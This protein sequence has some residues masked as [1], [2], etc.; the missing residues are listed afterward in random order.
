MAGGL[1]LC[2][3]AGFPGR[4]AAQLPAPSASASPAASE[5]PAAPATDTPPR[6]ATRDAVALENGSVYRGVIF[7]LVTGDHV[8]IMLPSGELKTFPMSEVRFAGPDSQMPV[9]AAGPAP[10]RQARGRPSVPATPPGE[11]AVHLT[12]AQ[13]DVTFWVERAGDDGP[14]ATGFSKLCTAPCDAALPAG[15]YRFA[16]A[17][18]GESPRTA[19]QVVNI[20]GDASLRADIVSRRDARTAG[21]VIG[22]VGVGGGLAALL[23]GSN[24]NHLDEKNTLTAVGATSMVLGAL[25]GIVFVLS[26]DSA[27]VRATSLDEPGEAAASAAGRAGERVPCAIGDAFALGWGMRF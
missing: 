8:S 3:F 1:A 19:K 11:Y 20:R 18:E 25:I 13:P 16:L 22:G 24:T 17:R 15:S 10:S 27:V 5:S 21:W 12:S 23:A 4:T 9:A 7:E 26:E 6:P 14:G 2:T